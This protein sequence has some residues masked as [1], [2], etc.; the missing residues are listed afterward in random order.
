MRLRRSTGKNKNPK[1]LEGSEIKA[2]ALKKSKGQ[3]DDRDA[4]L[5][6]VAEHG[7]ALQFAPDHLRGDREVVMT[8]VA[9]Y[10]YALEYATEELRGDREVATTAV[11]D[12]GYALEFAA[13]HLTG[14]R[15]VVMTAVATHGMALEYVTEELR[16]DK[17]IMEA[18]LASASATGR[19]PI[20]LKAR[21]NSACLLSFLLA[22][23]EEE[24]PKS[25]WRTF[26]AWA[27]ILS[28]D[29]VKRAFH[30]SLSGQIRKRSL[31]SESVL[32][33]LLN[34]AVRQVQ[35]PKLRP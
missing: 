21:L 2:L 5:R 7:S 25:V 8:A 32:A 34:I 11:A 31:V 9:T 18:A 6:R 17:E 24:K 10:G 27:V 35:Q 26:G 23:K 13:D 33:G 14:D 3:H 20:G 22:S 29:R 30:S 19:R 12:R 1:D 28:R 15:E 4:W 16:G